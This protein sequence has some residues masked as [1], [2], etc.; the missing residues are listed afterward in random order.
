MSKTEELENCV[1]PGPLDN[2]VR[3]GSFEL[4][5]IFK[6]LKQIQSQVK[7][8]KY[9]LVDQEIID[10]FDVIK[11]IFNN[12]NKF[13]K[14][15]DTYQSI[16]YFM[17]DFNDLKANITSTDLKKRLLTLF[18]R[19]DPQMITIQ[20]KIKNETYSKKFSFGNYLYSYSYLLKNTNEYFKKPII[21]FSICPDESTLDIALTI[22]KSRI[23]PIDPNLNVNE[24]TF[25]H[26]FY[27]SDLVNK[28]N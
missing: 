28:F 2:C 4:S 19:T 26:I 18:K 11:D 23:E 20:I 12:F 9:Y 13:R 27:A 7:N 1:R 6:T 15:N 21:D 5:D 25:K 10:N 3:P 8:E 14:C 17:N 24:F 16:V 22:I